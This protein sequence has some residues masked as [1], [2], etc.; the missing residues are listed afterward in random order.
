MI[1]KYIPLILIAIGFGCKKGIDA[2]QSK[3]AT[4]LSQ[5]T[6]AKSVVMVI[7]PA[8]FRDEELKIPYDYLKGLGHKVTVAST[9]MV[10]AVGMLGLQFKSDRLI[11]DIDPAQYDALIMVGGVGSKMFWDDT[12]AHRLVKYFADNNKVLAAICLAPVTL[13]RAGVLKDKNATCFPDVAGELRTSGA[14]Y[15]GKKVEISGNIITASGPEA[16]QEFAQ[17]IADKLK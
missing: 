16:A 11:R 1:Y 12:T 5:N 14:N 7:A 8:G 9:L 13:A 6:P 15:T 2:G 17:A 4:A 3:T 10:K